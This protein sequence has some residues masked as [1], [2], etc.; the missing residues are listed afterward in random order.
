MSATGTGTRDP[1]RTVSRA[2]VAHEGIGRRL[3]KGIGAGLIGQVLNFSSKILLVPLFLRAWGTDVYGEWLQISSFVAYLSLTE[4]GGQIYVVNR[5]TEAYARHDMALFR[6][7]LHTAL[8]LFIVVPFAVMALFIGAILLVPP[9]SFLEI[10][11]TSP[12]TVFWVSTI[13]ALHVIVSLPQGLLVGVYRAVGRLP[14]GVMLGNL[15]LFLQLGLVAAGLASGLGMVWIA[16]LQ[17]LP[18]L[19]VAGI[20]VH[21]L[22]SRHPEFQLLAPRQLDLALGRSL[23]KPSAQFFLIQIALALSVHGTVLVVG[24]LLSQQEV[25]V[26]TT[27]RMIGNVIIAV[28]A[29]VVHTAWPEMTRLSGTGEVDRL[30]GLFRAILRTTMFAAVAIATVLHFFGAWIYG[31]W[32]GG[33]LEFRSDLMGLILLYLVQAVFWMVCRSLLMATN[34]HR[35]LSVILVVSAVVTIALSYV[36][37]QHFG[38]RGVLA[39]IL[40][41]DLLL[42]FW[43][44]PYLVA[45]HQPGF[46]LAFFSREAAVVAAA[47]ACIAFVPWAAPLALLGLLAWWARSVPGGR[48]RMAGW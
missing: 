18:L 5:L 42:P 4:L 39:A 23:L 46:S 27:L 2:P 26:F 24:V 21:E 6:R 40:I 22:D 41:G 25:V 45:R 15:M 12:D 36:C 14:R 34:S 29:L 10:S 47:V 20:V 19:L 9:G 37:G 33:E 30:F 31:F 8:A 28:L 7:L 13:L 3:V 38:L 35:S 32:L 11:S 1:A 48:L 16:G 44:V 43:A 17:L